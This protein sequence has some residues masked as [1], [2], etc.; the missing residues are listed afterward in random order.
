MLNG[1]GG[2]F[3]DLFKAHGTLSNKHPPI[4]TI[5]ISVSLRIIGKLSTT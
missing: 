2:R 3:V 1:V 4:V 5:G